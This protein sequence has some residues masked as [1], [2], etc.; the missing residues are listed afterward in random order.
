MA[1]GITEQTQA[2]VA[3]SVV[4]RQLR[5][6]QAEYSGLMK[7]AG[8]G[9]QNAYIIK[10]LNSQLRKDGHL[11]GPRKRRSTPRGNARRRT[12]KKR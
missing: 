3:V 9:A 12:A 7:A 1:N 8:R 4:G 5:I 11:E 2:P 6:P 10:A